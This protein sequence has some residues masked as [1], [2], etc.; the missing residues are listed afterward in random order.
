MIKVLLADRQKL[1][2]YFS[3]SSNFQILEIMFFNIFLNIMDSLCTRL[4]K[5]NRRKH[6][7]LRIYLTNDKCS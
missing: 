2:V 4:I 3:N 7:I 6:I 1:V 5:S